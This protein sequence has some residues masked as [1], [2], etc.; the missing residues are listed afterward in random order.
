M[1]KSEQKPSTAGAKPA[2]GEEAKAN[3]SEDKKSA[4]DDSANAKPTG[5]QTSEDAITR[6]KNDHRKVEQ[7]F[8]AFEKATRG[9]QKQKLVQQ[10]CRELIIHAMLEEEIFYPACRAK[11]ENDD[12]LNEAQVE[13][14][15]AKTLIN[16]LLTGSSADE[17][18]GAQVKVLSELIRHHVAEEERRAEGIFAKAKA[19]GVD[20]SQIAEQM[21][22]RKAE[23]TAQADAGGLS[24]PQFRSFKTLSNS[25]EESDMAQSSERERRYAN[26]DED[27][28]YS[29]RS[30][31]DRDDDDGDRRGGRIPGR[32]EDGRFMSRD[33]DDRRSSR[34]SRE[35]EERR[36]NRSQSYGGR[37]DRDDDR[38]TASRG[39]DSDDRRGQRTPE[40]DDNGRFMRDDDDDRG[41]P[42]SN[43]GRDDDRRGSQ[44]A[45]SSGSRSRNEDDDNRRSSRGRDQGGWFGDS[46]GH[47]EAARQGWKRREDD[48]GRSGRDDD[49]D[50]RSR[51]RSARGVSRSR[52]DDDDRRSFRNESQGGWFGDSEGHSQAA[53]RGWESREDPNER[54]SSSGDNRSQRSGG[55]GNNRSSRDEGHGGWFGDPEG[56]AEA[57]R[58][59]W[60]GRR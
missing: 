29:A 3:A 45:R 16:E 20:T 55:R 57:S 50:D 39:R 59:G 25:K 15:S 11:I 35:D 19:A 21:L 2:N 8:E 12:I 31:R 46:G 7:L 14:D 60:D 13:H 56:H 4:A 18:F 17:Y 49:D 33:D 53:R 28:R 37:F 41:S 42:N 10:I 1:A 26:P 47:A 51:S 43:R 34:S 22:Q 32:D 30:S 27:R 54:R 23:L 40:R 48:R 6:L 24:R 9:P 44:S 38:K 52:D 58:R 5:M 36:S